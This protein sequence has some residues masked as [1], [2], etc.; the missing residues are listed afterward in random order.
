MLAGP[1]WEQEGV[2]AADLN[3][4]EIAQGQVDFDAICRYAYP[5]LFG[6]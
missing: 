4:N 2:L 6:Q 1:L 3:T 5:G